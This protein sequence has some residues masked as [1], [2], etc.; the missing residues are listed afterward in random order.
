MG[1]R[2]WMTAAVFALAL[3]GVRQTTLAQSVAWVT[4]SLESEPV[5]LNNQLYAVRYE[6]NKVSVFNFDGSIICQ[7]ID[8]I[9]T[10]CEGFALLLDKEYYTSASNRYAIRCLMAEDGSLT[11]P[12][13][14]LYADAYPFFSEGLLAVSNR[15]GKYGFMGPDG[16][17]AINCNYNMAYPFSEG[18]ACVQNR[19]NS[20]C[21]IDKAGNKIK[22][23]KA[24]RNI[25]SGSSFYGGKALVR[26]KDG[27]YC[28]IDHNGSIVNERETIDVNYDWKHRISDE[29]GPTPATISYNEQI[30]PVPEQGLYGYK[31]AA[32]GWT[33]PPQFIS[34]GRF[35]S[36]GFAIV[37]TTGS[38]YGILQLIDGQ[39]YLSQEPGTQ[40]DGV[41]QNKESVLVK[42]DV[43]E[44]YINK[45]LIL[46]IASCDTT[47]SEMLPA[48]SSS[49]RMIQLQLYQEDRVYRITEGS[50]CLYEQVMAPLTPDAKLV[51]SVEKDSKRAQKGDIQ[52]ITITITNPGRRNFNGT[53]SF[54]GKNF[55]CKSQNISLAP[56][57]RIR[58]KG[59]FT[60]VIKRENR[61]ITITSE[62]QEE[63][64]YVSVI[65]IVG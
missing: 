15:L 18:L 7:E 63:K 30:I 37:S 34:A 39:F 45:P 56:G 29:V 49:V 2:R 59:Y 22:L 46:A 17:L 41:E 58:I 44:Y 53:V 21:Y 47:W 64:L 54:K 3:F 6:N 27:R 51:F 16:T 4:Q 52:N 25:R 33:V 55:V 28:Y 1:H 60:K 20:T 57:Q 23:D 19:L 38:R 32:E 61:R 48:D 26:T 43:P 35:N 14:R 12:Q 9:T 8:S 50:L 65:P 24:L 31:T 36:N 62:K 5:A 40:A 11:V 42:V 13:S 10:F